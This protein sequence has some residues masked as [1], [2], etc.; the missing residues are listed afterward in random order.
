M[1]LVSLGPPETWK[2]G[3]SSCQGLVADTGEVKCWANKYLCPL[4]YIFW[5]RFL[6]YELYFHERTFVWI[7]WL[8]NCDFM[9]TSSNGEFFNVTGPLCGEFTGHQWIPHTKASDAELHVFFDLR[10][11]KQLNKQLWSWWFEM[12]SCSLWSHRNVLDQ[13]QF[14]KESFS[15]QWPKNTLFC[16][17][18]SSTQHL[19]YFLYFMTF[20][21]WWVN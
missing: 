11:N 7:F 2:L 17:L 20:S 14:F 15:W 21:K 13:F 10:L 3:F 9:M 6:I 8:Q 1:Y 16:W 12:P 19:W 4:W 5:Q 18:D